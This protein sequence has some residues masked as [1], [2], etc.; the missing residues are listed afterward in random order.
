MRRVGAFL[1]ILG[2][3]LV[4]G[5]IAAAFWLA[6]LGC[7]MGVADGKCKQDALELLID[8][9]G[10]GSGAIFWVAIIAGL[11]LFWRGKRMRARADADD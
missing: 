7:A 5:A 2:A 10:S 4:V 3:N 9:M 1:M 8:V 11:L 6:S